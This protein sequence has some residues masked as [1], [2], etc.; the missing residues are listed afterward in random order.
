MAAFAHLDLQVLVVEDS[1]FFRTAITG[2]LSS[3]GIS[4]VDGVPSGNMAIELCQHRHFDLILCDQN[5]GKGK[6]GQQTLEA[7]R[8][9]NMI[10]DNT[11]FMMISGDPSRQTVLASSDVCADDF[12]SKPLNTSMLQKRIGRLLSLKRAF[13]PVFAALNNSEFE[14][15]IERLQVLAEEGQRFASLANKLLGETL[16]QVRRIDEAEQH[17]RQQLQTGPLEWAR[18]GLAFVYQMRGDIAE[19]TEL[20]NAIIAD[21]PH[22]L[23]AYDGL[24]TNHHKTYD[25]LRLQ[26]T[27]EK[28]VRVSPLSILRQKNLANMAEQN[29]DIPTALKALRECV[30][31]GFHSCHGDWNDAYRFGMNTAD[32]PQALI[33]EQDKLPQEAL[34]ILKTATEYF[35]VSPDELLRMQFLRGRLQF[36]A[37]QIHDGKSAIYRAESQ[38]ALNESKDIATD[39]ARV[40]A[41]H[42]IHEHE[43]A[44][45]LSQDLTRQYAKDQEALNQLD[46]VLNEPVSQQ[47]RNVL[48]EANKKGIALYNQKKYDEALLCF[49]RARVLFPR[50]IGIQLNICQAYIG[51][52]NLN[53][54]SELDKVIEDLLGHIQK[55]IKNSDPQYGRFIKLRNL[56]G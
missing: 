6:N 55:L 39:I 28:A 3:L 52:R 1:N 34:N 53:A 10:K 15:A 41:M 8:H 11:A 30:R 40:K 12:L 13:K 45:Q 33:D 5:L 2:M 43:K 32:A 44:D 47:N 20:F 23:A 17:Y 56:A 18:L 49:E 27:L 9:I 22:C 19:S 51:K 36:L 35:N 25:F 42:T 54:D 46:Q 38:Y 37:R 14:T 48:A 29:G 31:L 4:K 26:Q 21:N 16:L 7:L 50:H 24:A